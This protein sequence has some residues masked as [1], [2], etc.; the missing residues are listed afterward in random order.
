MKKTFLDKIFLIPFIVLIIAFITFIIAVTM[1]QLYFFLYVVSSAI[2]GSLI[3]SFI[4][5]WRNKLKRTH[6]IFFLLGIIVV[7]AVIILL[8]VFNIL[9]KD[10]FA[11]CCINIFSIGTISY[12]IQAINKRR[13]RLKNKNEK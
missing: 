3:S 4:F 9:N 10:Y 13:K 6:F 1:K 5:E 2:I 11:L 12:L 7:V 8:F